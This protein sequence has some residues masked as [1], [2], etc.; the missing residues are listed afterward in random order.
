VVIHD[1]CMNRVAPAGDEAFK[2][3]TYLQNSVSQWVFERI[4]CLWDIPKGKPASASCVDCFQLL[5]CYVAFCKPVGV[6]V[7]PKFP[8]G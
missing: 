1:K 4:L 8:S 5:A 7:P 2:F 6:I 3:L